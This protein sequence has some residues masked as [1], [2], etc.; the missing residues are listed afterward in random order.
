MHAIHRTPIFT[1]AID[2]L[3]NTEEYLTLQ[4][5]L[6]KRPGRGAVIPGSKGL[7]KTR[8]PRPGAGKRGGL[9]IVYYW[10]PATE[11]FYL[12]Y[13]YSKSGRDDLTPTQRRTLAR[14]VQEEFQ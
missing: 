7:R 1:R 11:T 4:S 3:L 13:A 6:L 12:L 10:D 8:W 2:K 9:R 14:L 5:A